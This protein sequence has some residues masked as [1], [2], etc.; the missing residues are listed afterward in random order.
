M[1][2]VRK[3]KERAVSFITEAFNTP[4]RRMAVI[5]DPDHNHITIHKQHT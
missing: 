1:P 4:V 3:M 5:E 2:F